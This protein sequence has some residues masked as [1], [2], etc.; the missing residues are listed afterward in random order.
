MA[1]WFVVANVSQAASSF[2]VGDEGRVDALDGS[3]HLL[4]QLFDRVGALGDHR[5]ARVRNDR[6]ARVRRQRGRVRA[7]CGF[8][9][10]RRLYLRYIRIA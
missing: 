1:G 8:D 6:F 7:C 9:G 4:E 3:R 2:R 5:V 10:E